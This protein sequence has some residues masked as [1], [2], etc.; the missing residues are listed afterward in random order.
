MNYQAPKPH[1]V[2]SCRYRL[3]KPRAVPN[4]RCKARWA[5]SPP[6]MADNADN[7][8]NADIG[9]IIMTQWVHCYLTG[10]A[11]EDIVD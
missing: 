5:S 9:A 10:H 8:D 11:R 7:A 3:L 4:K 2:A 6:I 1:Q